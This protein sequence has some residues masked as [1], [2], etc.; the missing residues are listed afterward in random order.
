MQ[1]ITFIIGIL[2]SILVLLLRPVY[3]L[4]VYFCILV[5]YPEYLRL[6]IGTI[7]FSV[8]RIVV[9]ALLLRC[10]ISDKLR[11]RLIWSTL[12][13]WVSLSIA[14]TV[15]IYTISCGLSVEAIENRGGLIIDTW[16]TYLTVR[17]IVTNKKSLITFIKI[18]GVILAPLAIHS[19]IEAVTGWQPF[20]QMVQFRT[21][22]PI[23]SE[24]VLATQ[25]RWGLTRAIGPFGHPIMLGSCFVMFL[26]L[27]WAIRCQI[28][29][30]RI[31]SYL[32]SVVVILGAISSMSSGPWGM[33]LIVFLCLALEKWK[34][35]TKAIIIFFLLLC[36]L[37]EFGS[38][39]LLYHV[40]LEYINLGKGDW[41]SRARLIDAAIDNINEW[42][43]AGYGGIDPG[44]GSRDGG[45][46][47]GDFTDANNEFILI[48]MEAG[49]FAVFALCGMLV[50]AFRRLVRAGS[51]TKDTQLKSLYWSLGTALVGVIAVWQGVSFFGQMNALFYCLLGVIGSACVLIDHKTLGSQRYNR[52]NPTWNLAY[53]IPIAQ[54]T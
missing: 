16:F 39:R 31:L 51:Q 53:D 8:G 41:Y 5:W 47:Y 50:L 7:D 17:F 20:F 13:T 37:A 38:N 28:G 33:L 24:D 48:G 14:T 21:W 32:L 30:W 23:M 25:T 1:G 36:A 26:P 3:T 45:Y 9:M 49:F 11:S 40:A 10:L 18:M 22:R 6:S 34:R 42:W 4:G 29:L 19:A 12:D 15:I 54:K 46:F 2:G 43:L 44:W 52:L 27:I 35:W